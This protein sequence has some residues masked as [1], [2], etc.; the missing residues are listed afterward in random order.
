MLFDGKDLSKWRKAKGEDAKWKVENGY[1]E[2]NETGDIFTKEEFGPDVQLHVEWAAPEPANG[3]ARAA[4]TAA[5]S[6]SAATKFRC[7][8]TT[9][10]DL[11]RRPGH[12]DLRLH[13]A[14]G[15]CQPPARPVAEL[16]HHFRRSALSRISKL[17][18]PA[19]V[20]ILHNGV[21]TQNHIALIGETPHQQVGTYHAH[22]EKGPIKLQDHGNP[23]RY[24]N[25]W[26]RELHL[27]GR[28]ISATARGSANSGRRRRPRGCMGSIRRRACS[29]GHRGPQN[30]ALSARRRRRASIRFRHKRCG[31]PGWRWTRSRKKKCDCAEWFS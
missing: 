15:E 28:T 9:R 13:A 27:P 30:V 4:A 3:A 14:A 11:S 12:G 8:I 26:I 2:V 24:R 31:R 25:I 23:V 22:R 21:V 1:M 16:R 6:S 7:S 5:S 17:D 29:V 10:A 18:K 19:Y 20:T